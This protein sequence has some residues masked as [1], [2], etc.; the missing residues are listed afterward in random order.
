M[1]EFNQKLEDFGL[2]TG[3]IAIAAILVPLAV[4]TFPLWL[5]GFIALRMLIERY[6]KFERVL[7]RHGVSLK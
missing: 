6:P 3:I 1:N 5:F 4:I 2:I 7:Q